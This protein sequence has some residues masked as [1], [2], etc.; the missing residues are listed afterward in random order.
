MSEL[1]VV[2]KV[3]LIVDD[4]VMLTF[5]VKIISVCICKHV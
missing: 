4:Q 2:I 3:V 5:V 1:N